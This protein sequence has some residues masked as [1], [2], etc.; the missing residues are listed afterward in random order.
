MIINYICVLLNVCRSA[1]VLPKT[2]AA[3]R[4]KKPAATKRSRTLRSAAGRDSV[5]SGVELDMAKKQRGQLDSVREKADEEQTDSDNC[6]TSTKTVAETRCET[7]ESKDSVG[8]PS[9]TRTVAE[10]KRKT[11]ENKENV[12]SG[13]VSNDVKQTDAENKR[14]NDQQTDKQQ[15]ANVVS[16]PASIVSTQ[17]LIYYI[18][19]IY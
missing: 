3:T 17:I 13:Q 11:D 16:S 9:S 4:R 10:T 1:I 2:P 8:S 12:E 6:P 18:I 15:I 7:A 14:A 5:D 19:F